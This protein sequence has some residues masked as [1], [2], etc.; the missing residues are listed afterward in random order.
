MATGLL[1][2]QRNPDSLPTKKYPRAPILEAI[3]DLHVDASGEPNISALASVMVEEK[4]RYPKQDNLVT[5]SVVVNPAA[6]VATSASQQLIGFR[7]TSAAM[8]AVVQVRSNGFAFSRLAPYPADGWE[9]WIPEAQRLF[10]RYIEVTGNRRVNRLAV[11]YINKIDIPCPEGASVEPEEYFATYPRIGDHIGNTT[12][13]LMRAQVETPGFENGGIVLTQGTL[14][15]PSAPNTI[16]ILLD[17]DVFQN[18][19]IDAQITEVWE[20]LE[21]LHQR[22]TST[23]EA[24]ITPSAQRLFL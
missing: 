14:E 16:P 20:R 18:V 13:F 24:C 21:E 23:F 5:A 22:A 6:G 15:E 10:R 11:R 3:V 17:I 4:E 8:A 19:A 2:P 9:A 7:Y 12:R 1:I